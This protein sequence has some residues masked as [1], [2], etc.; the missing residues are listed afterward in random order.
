M[1][2]VKRLRKSLTDNTSQATVP[3]HGDL[4]L[5]RVACRT[6]HLVYVP[7]PYNA[8]DVID[9]SAPLIDNFNFPRHLAWALAND[10][11]EM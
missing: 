4:D 1:T 10:V 9:T 8:A 2:L 7:C 6:L 5:V 3:A 11:V